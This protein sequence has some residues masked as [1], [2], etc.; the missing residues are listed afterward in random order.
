MHTLMGVLLTIRNTT[1]SLPH[2]ARCSFLVKTKKK[3]FHPIVS[4]YIIL[5]KYIGYS[6]VLNAEEKE[7]EENNLTWTTDKI[8]LCSKHR[9]GHQETTSSTGRGS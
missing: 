6:N 8:P 3:V 9:A 7:K 2:T 5:C 4:R 1:P